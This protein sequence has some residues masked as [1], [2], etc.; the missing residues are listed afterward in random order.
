M[1]LDAGH[2]VFH[3]GCEGS[4]P[5]CTENID[6][7]SNAYR[8]S[9]YPDKGK[10]YPQFDYD[11][12]DEYHGVFHRR[13]AEE[14]SKRNEDN[15]F[16]LCFWGHGHKPIADMAGNLVVVEA[17]IGYSETFA[18]YRVFESYAWMHWVSGRQSQ[19][20]GKFY[21]AV[22]PN[23]FDP[24][25]F[26]F[27]KEREDWFLYLGRIIKSKGVELAVDLT[28]RIG[29][30]IVIAGQGSLKHEYDGIDLRGNHIEFAGYA[31][32]EKRKD[33]MSRAKALIMPTFHHE[34]FGRTA[35]EAQLSGC[36]VICTD[37]GSFNEVV[38]HGIT[39]YRCHTMEQFD[40][41]A[42]N[43]GDISP[44]AC[45]HWASENFSMS[46]VMPKYQEYFDMLYDLR[47]DGW[48]GRNDDRK[49]LDWLKISFP[50]ISEDIHEDISHSEDVD[51]WKN[52]QLWEESW[53]KNG[54]ANG[55]NTHYEEKKQIEF[56][57]PRM[58]LKFDKNDRIDMGGKNVLDIGGG[59]AS[60]LLKVMN[61]GRMKVVDPLLPPEWALQRY[62]FSGIEF[63]SVM[64]ENLRE[65]GWDEVWI[66]NVLQHTMDPEAVLH[67]ALEAGRVLRV[68]EW[69]DTGISPGHI[70]NLTADFFRRVLGDIG[71]NDTV[72]V[73]NGWF[74]NSFSVVI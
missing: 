39:G 22:I 4:D 44:D 17:S 9:F 57:A 59:P 1:L 23:F 2:E 12:S 69:T 21:D 30:K 18:P 33:L 5:P 27:N 47:N 32:V 25:E 31:D 10:D 48:G 62:E 8:E 43:I 68:F 3:Y 72:D 29:A 11:T 24:S 46:K 28:N 26:T 60:M 53:W 67:K 61:G 36:P 73:G 38:L 70:H 55:T 15:D 74:C 50:S 13:C 34:S 20:H 63:E 58:G 54:V 40:W 65:R 56:Y 52:A 71:V 37:H 14:I 42:R 35:M 7:V 51:E 6:V 19:T 64:G 49:N 66:Y 41:A 16:L 45:Y